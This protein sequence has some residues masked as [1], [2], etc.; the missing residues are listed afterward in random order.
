[1]TEI[2]GCGAVVAASLALLA[3]AAAS[4]DCKLLQIAEFHVDPSSQ[5]PVVDGA[6]NGQPVKV[7][8]DTGASF[9]TVRRDEALRLGLPTYGL[10]G[11]R[12]RIDDAS[13]AYSARISRFS[14]GDLTK[15]N[16]ELQVATEA[17]QR[18]DASVVLGD[19]FL[20]KV[21]VEFDLAQGAMRL[22]HPEG[23]A[24]AQL[25]YWGASYSQA[26][27]LT[28]DPAAPVI[29]AYVQVNGQQVLA[30]LASGTYPSVIDAS[31]AT[32]AG[33]TGPGGEAVASG[34]G[35]GDASWTGKFASF[36]F[37]DEKVSNVK[38][39]VGAVAPRVDYT[40]TGGL[41][42]QNSPAI[43]IGADFLHAHRVIVDPQDHLL[44][45]SYVGGPVFST[46]AR[47]VSR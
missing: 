7:L 9:S 13:S 10:N 21:T 19:D 16:L 17:G 44:M 41:I 29:E 24:P 35:G 20:A 38:L 36:A 45:F 42:R 3:P 34:V 26:A 23:C 28:A 11:V 27:M 43:L 39:Q 47:S 8:I 18:P 31:A 40:P 33:A 14:L 12:S 22:F 6:L 1:M 30:E 15:T 5:S 2:T 32:A 25:V 4:A 37:G 46:A